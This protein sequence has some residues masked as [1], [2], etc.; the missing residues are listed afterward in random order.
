M[1]AGQSSVAYRPMVLWFWRV[2]LCFVQLF[3]RMAVA[4][5][6]TNGVKTLC[7]A[8]F[9]FCLWNC[10]QRWPCSDTDSRNPEKLD[11][12][13]L[14]IF[15]HRKQKVAVVRVG[16]EMCKSKPNPAPS[17]KNRQEAHSWTFILCAPV[18]WRRHT[19][20]WRQQVPSSKTWHPSLISEE[21]LPD[22]ML[23]KSPQAVPTAS[24]PPGRWPW[25]PVKMGGSWENQWE[26]RWETMRFRPKW[27][28]FLI[29]CSD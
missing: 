13:P 23:D 16:I 4:P 22:Q 10:C 19:H 2:L 20:L 17:L 11:W 28:V 1:S 3:F 5:V 12:Q 14:Q 26:N 25:R 6:K 9:R 21:L 24:A 8:S 27:S 15:P 18:K 7:V 29:S